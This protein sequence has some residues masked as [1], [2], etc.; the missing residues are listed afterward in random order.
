MAL[1]FPNLSR[2][3]DADRRR[4]RF[5]GHDNAIEVQFFLDEN[6]L[7]RLDP[8][9]KNVEAGMLQTFDAWRE[10][11]H[12]VAGKAYAFNRRAFYTLAATDF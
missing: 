2:S 7:F 9:T 10:R 4:V 1:T 12:E 3:Y 8:K 5:W 11:I 6:A